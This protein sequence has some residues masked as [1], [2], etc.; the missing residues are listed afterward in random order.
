MTKQAKSYYLQ[1]SRA[2]PGIVHNTFILN[3]VKVSIPVNAAT[4]C[5]ISQ[6]IASKNIPRMAQVKVEWADCS[7]LGSPPEVKYLIPAKTSI[8]SMA[9][10]PRPTITEIT[11]PTMLSISAKP[12]GSGPKDGEGDGVILLT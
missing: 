11:L 10:N 4:S 1:K 8:T 3:I 5:K 2:V 6:A 9:I 7:A 12:A